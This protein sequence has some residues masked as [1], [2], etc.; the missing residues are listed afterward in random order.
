MVLEQAPRIAIASLIAYLVSQ[1]HDVWAFHFWKKKTGGKFLWL[2]NNVSTISSQLL[3]S[4]LFITIAFYGIMPIWPLIL[5]QRA[6]KIIIAAIDT[7][8]LYAS[9]WMMD[10]IP[11]KK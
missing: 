4:A 8:F 11:A 3:D 9:I 10:K 1:H 7:P 6:V 2:R 5:G